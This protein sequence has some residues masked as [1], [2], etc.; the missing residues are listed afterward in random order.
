MNPFLR[1]QLLLKARRLSKELSTDYVSTKIEIRLEPDMAH[2]RAK[3][4][5]YHHYIVRNDVPKPG[6]TNQT[7]VSGWE[8]DERG[9]P[10]PGCWEDRVVRK[11][12]ES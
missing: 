7:L 11:I 3:G 2:G 12:M 6:W 5:P 9:C 4:P 1:L 8:H 10:F